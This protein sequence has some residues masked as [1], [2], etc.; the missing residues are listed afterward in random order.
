MKVT[1]DKPTR[2][3]LDGDARKPTKK[4]RIKIRPKSIT[5]CVPVPES[6]SEDQKA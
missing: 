5:V 1:F 2:Y 3:E 4:L 6:P